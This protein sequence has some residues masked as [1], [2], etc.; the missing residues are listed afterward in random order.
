[1][2][3]PGEADP[4]VWTDRMIVDAAAGL[5]APL[6]KRDESEVVGVMRLLN[7]VRKI[8]ECVERSEG[9]AH[10]RERDLL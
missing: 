4:V 2:S 8:A 7:T 10:H 1:M 3:K 6:V 5:T 9:W